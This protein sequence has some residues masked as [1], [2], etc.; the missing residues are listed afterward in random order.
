[1]VSLLHDQENNDD[2]DYFKNKLKH[3]ST[4]KNK[5]YESMPCLLCNIALL[6]T[7]IGRYLS[8]EKKTWNNDFYIVI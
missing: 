3:N 8:H 7:V 4:H 6:L 5:I 2:Y 1:M